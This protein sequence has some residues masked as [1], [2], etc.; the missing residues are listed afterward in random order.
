[1]KNE[2]VA[3]MSAM[4]DT[5]MPPAMVVPDDNMAKVANVHTSTMMHESDAAKPEADPITMFDKHAAEKAMAKGDPHGKIKLSSV[6]KGGIK[7][8]GKKPLW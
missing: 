5:P 7:P 3:E 6:P 1:M 8:S 2:P 4:Q